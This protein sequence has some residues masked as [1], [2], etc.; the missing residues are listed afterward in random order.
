MT[1]WPIVIPLNPAPAERHAAEELRDLIIRATGT[2]LE[3]TPSNS[4]TEGGL[5]LGAA[6]RLDTAD[7][8]DEA[9]R[10][11]INDR[12]VEIAGGSP[13]GTLYGVYTF[14]EHALG[15]RFLTPDCTHVPRADPGQTLHSGEYL[16]RPRFAWRHS[17]YGANL[18]HPEFAAHARN[19]AAS[20]RPELGGRSTWSLISHSVNEYVPV[21]R[22]GKDHPEYFSLVNGQ[23]RSFMRDDQFESGGTQPCF[24][25][26]DVKRLIISGVL[27][28][29]A[30]R[31]QTDG[32]IAIS[33]NDN[34]MY[35]RCDR[36]KTIDEWESSHMGA[37]L[38]LVNEA[39]DAV[40]RTRPNVFV[41]TLAYQFSRTPPR[42]LNPRPNVAIQLCSIEACQIHVLNDPSC[43]KNVAF[44]RDLEGW[45]KVCKH[46][47]VWNYNTNF[48]CYNSPCPNLDV[49]GPNLRFLAS[50]GISG[51][52]MQAAGNAQNTEL[53]ELRNY[54]ISRL[55]W[56]P[57]NDDRK[58]VDEFLTLYYG[59]AARM[60]RA[61]L[62]LIGDAARESG[63]HQH[64]FGSAASYGI[65]ASVA[66]Q[67][68]K[69]LQQGM[70]LAENDD[71]KSRVEK[72][73]IGP[74]TVLID[75]LARWLRGHQ[76]QINAGSS[77]KVPPEVLS[78]IEDEIRTVFHLY[79]KFKVDRFAEWL[80]VAQVR[81]VLPEHLT[82]GTVDHSP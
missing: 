4:P 15:V 54:L 51:V 48:T 60:V 19:N 41:G 5:L 37:L 74:H 16:V 79:D 69:L 10:I 70:A 71:V 20:D 33:Q 64:C 11:R 12:K 62:T 63:I 56:D 22:F 13:R 36:C 29:L 9:F 67:G 50:Q 32:N 44:C 17:Y 75:P 78:G 30:R 59:R 81:S 18:A 14:L 45:C 76:H 6:S 2:R 31:R 68:L 52:F 53:C 42:D 21:A 61:Y 82:S 38:T 47:Y 49:I 43:P 25:N 66:R 77:E 40:A 24:T 65:G 35:C 28:R 39:A 7:L 72:V 58:V 26:Q 1:S 55:L 80:T 73:T 23:R 34:T 46:I 57:T 3:I 8:G 27:D